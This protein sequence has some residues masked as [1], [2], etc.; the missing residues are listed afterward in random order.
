MSSLYVHRPHGLWRHVSKLLRL[1]ATIT[2]NG[3]RRAKLGRK[4]A[5]LFFALTVIAALVGIYALSWFILSVLRSPEVARLSADT[6]GGDGSLATYADAAGLASAVPVIITT[7]AFGVMLF[8]SFGVL[9][10]ALYLAGDMDFL[11]SAPLPVRAV[12][13]AKLLQAILPNLGLVGLFG[14]PVLYGLGASGGYSPLYYPLVPVILAALALTAAGLAALLV[15][16]VVRFFPARRVAE[17]LGLL[18]GLISLVCSQSGQFARLA[19]MSSARAVL[20]LSTLAR[21]DVPWSPLAWA[22]R[23]L[24]ALGEGRWLSG[25]AFT[26]L[27]C[28]L[29]AAVMAITLVAAERLYCSGWVRLQMS[30]HRKNAARRSTAAESWGD[31]RAWRLLPAGVRGLVAK[32]LLTIPRD[33]RNMSQLIIPMVLGVIYAIMF[34]RSGGQA[35]A[36]RGEAPAWFMEILTNVWAYANIGIA[37]FVGWAVLPRLALMGFSQEGRWYWILKTAPVSAGKLLAG[38]FLVAYLPALALGWV[39]MV[40]ISVLR[41]TDP[42]TLLF[43]LATIALCLAGGCGL[44]LAFGVAG[45]N[46]EWQDPRQMVLGATGWFGALASIAYVLVTLGLF[47]IPPIV[48]V[49]LGRSQALGQGVG[50]LAGGTASLLCALLPPR[51][52]RSRVPR[53]GEG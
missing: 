40:A 28:G 16:G 38:K 48:L 10:Q 50:L 7:G 19:D 44:N 14:L 27:I 30:R 43:G 9:L 52:V 22:G 36:G 37:L 32:D 21:L 12:F 13:L 33:L 3:F 51:W 15:L 31:S 25:A 4:I 24:V 20:A 29:S 6:V 49:L 45:A 47:F 1:Q 34:L 23:G 11:L 35:P 5:Y 46:L 2:L 8:T 39:F 42:L 18:G 26:A 53:L 17:V 41:R